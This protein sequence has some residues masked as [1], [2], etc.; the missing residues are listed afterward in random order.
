MQRRRHSEFNEAADESVRRFEL[1]RRQHMDV[2]RP[3]I[4]KQ[5]LHEAECEAQRARRIMLDAVEND[6]AR[7]GQRGQNLNERMADV[8]AALEFSGGII[9][10]R[11]LRDPRDA[12]VAR[13]P[14]FLGQRR[15]AAA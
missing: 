4:G 1:R 6:E 5:V 2:L 8:D 3:G 15:L 9:V 13:L 7:L 14:D 12:L 11:V 10:Q